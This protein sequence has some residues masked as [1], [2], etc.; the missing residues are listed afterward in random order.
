M[1]VRGGLPTVVGRLRETT[2]HDVIQRRRRVGLDSRERLRIALE[3]RGNQTRLRCS[4]EGTPGGHHFEEHA[5]EGPD[6]RS[7]VGLPALELLGRHVLERSQDR[8]LP[9]QRCSF[10]D[11]RGRC[12]QAR[13]DGAQ[14]A[15]HV[16]LGQTEVQQLSARL[17]EHHVAW[18]QIAVNDAAAVRFVERISN[19]GCMRY[20]L[21]DRQ[22]S[23][24]Q[25]IGQS[26]AV[27]ILHHQKLD[28]VLSADIVKCADMRMAQR[29]DGAGFALE[30][31]AELGV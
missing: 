18:L 13:F 28:S 6:V 4:L 12:S 21:L 25:P 1:N 20:G 23:S 2:A 14:S 30:T 3:N 11:W 26:L 10:S 24:L 9:R 17:R 29:G 19:L 5:A 15:R 16:G 22:G 8:A 27:E 7:R 31:L